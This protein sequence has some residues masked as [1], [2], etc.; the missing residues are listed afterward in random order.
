MTL[1]SYY[2]PATRWGRDFGYRDQIYTL[3]Y[4]R[5]QDIRRT[6]PTGSY[7]VVTDIVSLS[8]GVVSHIFKQPKTGWEVVVDT[9]RHR[10]RYEIHGHAMDFVSQ[11]TPI[12]AGVDRIARNAGWGE[13]TGSSWGGPHDHFV[14]SDHPDAGHNTRRH[15]YDPR[16]FILAALAAPAGKPSKPIDNPTRK[17]R[18]QM[19]TAAVIHTIGD[20]DKVRKGAIVDYDAGVFSPFGWFS[21]G[22]ANGVA[23]GHGLESSG[24]VTEGHYRQIKRD[25]AAAAERSGKVF[26]DIA[27]EDVPQIGE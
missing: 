20:D 1:R 8:D 18:K 6:D 22:Y 5:G 7:S 9:G 15:V 11:G 19:S 4:H 17:R 26:V 10:G 14:I 21:V 25:V 24:P 27:D 12:T 16:P 2:D 13:F 3:G 23:I